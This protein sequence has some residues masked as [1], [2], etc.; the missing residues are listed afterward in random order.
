M[1]QSSGVERLDPIFI[2]QVNEFYNQVRPILMLSLLHV[3]FAPSLFKALSLSLLL[4]FSMLWSFR[5]YPVAVFHLR[6]PRML[7][8][9]CR[10][11]VA[12]ADLPFP[13]VLPRSCT[14]RLV[15][16]H[17]GKNSLVYLL[18]FSIP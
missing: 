7:L 6:H 5:D 3:L 9:L 2:S 14:G 11:F 15:P 8:V 10:L 12:R 4:S 1:A 13:L 17:G 16:C 18:P